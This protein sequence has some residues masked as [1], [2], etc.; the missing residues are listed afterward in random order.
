MKNT[1][2]LQIIRILLLTGTFLAAL[3]VIF[4]DYSMD[5]EYQ[6]M[7]SYRQ[8]SGDTLFGTMWEPHQTSAF[9][10]TLLMGIYH[11]VTG[12]FTGI[13]I[14]LRVC[15]T[16]I[17]GG[18]AFL[19]CRTLS[20]LLGKE[21]ALYL[22]LIWFNIV[23]KLI[24]IPEF[25]NLQVWF[26]TL[27]ILCIMAYETHPRKKGHALLIFLGGIC[28]SL[29]ILS[30]PSMLVLYPFA[31]LYFVF[32]HPGKRLKNSLYFTAACGLCA[33]LFLAL[34]LQGISLREFL[35]NLPYVLSFD[36]THSLDATAGR[37]PLILLQGCLEEFLYLLPA[38]LLA[39]LLQLFLRRFLPDEKKASVSSGAALLVLT[40]L[41]AEGIQLIFW[42]ICR[43]GFEKP[44]LH[45]FAALLAGCLLLLFPG[46]SGKKEQDS[47]LFGILSSL[48]TF[49]AVLYLSD[50]T[51]YYAIP[52]ALTG[53]LWGLALLVRRLQNLP[54]N[55]SR[56]WILLL[57]MSFLCLSVFG[58]G[59][60]LR[61]GRINDITGLR[62]IMKQGPALGI[63]SDYMCAYIY[64]SNYA[65]FKDNIPEGSKVLIVTN[66]VDSPG[67]T[68]YM[69]TDAKVCHFSIV[70]PT[71]YDE[72]LLAYWK[73]YPEKIPD[74]MVVDCWYGQL[75]EDPDSWIM[76]YIENDFGYSRMVDGKYVRFYIK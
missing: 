39:L 15:T 3:K 57:L 68:P 59:F 4:V 74:I 34:V 16:L 6:L 22:S 72:R 26:G 71:S 12:T 23:P 13:L 64:N 75:Q 17:Q 55:R 42:G 49:G 24:Q 46:S 36:L 76:R 8:L 41:F 70:D 44:S 73:L 35:R 50:L 60:T 29:E 48:L 2:L 20:P 40:I 25:G 54:E 30:Y 52:H 69:F 51:F 7:M 58:K 63:L 37:K 66:M 28:L 45:L 19:I 62:G 27:L 18:I 33:L 65:D 5:E 11:L 67:T 47:F 53:S 21:P 1:R 61:G 14:F 38:V 32:A 56:A 31:I 43:T 9:L 10:C